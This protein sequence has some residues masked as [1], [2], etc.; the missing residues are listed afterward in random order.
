[1]SLKSAI[2]RLATLILLGST[3]S[4]TGCATLD[5][6]DQGEIIGGVVG[7]VLGSQIGDGSGQTVAIIIGSIAGSMIGRQ[8]G[9][10]MD[11][12][13]RLNTALALRDSRTGEG[14]TWVNP[15]N[16]ARYTVT[17]TRTFENGNGPCRDFRLDANVG[18][19]PNQEVNGTACLQSDGSWMIV[20]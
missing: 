19:Q 18:G 17:P 13:D 12:T 7:G 11:E 15:D 6:G 20:S 4:L 10:S 8:I 16:G 3:L 14:A 5:R 2:P 1:M 9:E